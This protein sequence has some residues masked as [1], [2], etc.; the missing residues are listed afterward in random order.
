MNIIYTSEEMQ[1][2]YKKNGIRSYIINDDY[3]QW[4]KDDK[5]EIIKSQLK[6]NELILN[7]SLKKEQLV[8]VKIILR[9]L[10]DDMTNLYTIICDVCGNKQSNL[11]LMGAEAISTKTSWGYDSLFD[12]QTHKL[13]MC[14]DC[15]NKHIMNTNLG[16]YVK[17]KYY[18]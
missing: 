5:E 7:Q 3:I 10:T 9:L 4:Q 2:I 17:V 13:I 15:Y 12:T 6:V 11:T 16:Q 14:C 1:E 18:M 8:T